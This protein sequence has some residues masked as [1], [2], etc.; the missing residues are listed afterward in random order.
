MSAKTTA[1]SKLLALWGRLSGLPGG[2]TAFALALGWMVPYTGTIRPRVEELAPGMARVVLRDR[3][4][5]RNHLASVHAVALANLGELATGLAMVG[6]LP[7]TVRGIL[8]GLEVTYLKKARGR[9]EATCRCAVPTVTED[10]EHTAEARIVDAAG[11]VVAT[12]TARWR[13]GPVPGRSAGL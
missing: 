2:K 13:L 10:T 5:V 7:P 12:A 3:R 1:P 8:V 9:L 4:R 11:D 6:A